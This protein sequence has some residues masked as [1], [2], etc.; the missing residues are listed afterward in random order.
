MAVATPFA[1]VT[2]VA[3]TPAF[4]TATIV[5][6]NAATASVGTPCGCPYEQ[7][8]SDCPRDH[9]ERG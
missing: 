7:R 4:A 9:R 1:A 3:V 2:T 8:R 5:A 6:I